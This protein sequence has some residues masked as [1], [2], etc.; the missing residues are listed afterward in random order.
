MKTRTCLSFAFL[1]LLITG[2]SFACRIIV[3]QEPMPL[4]RP[5]RSSRQPIITKSHKAEI[6]ITNQAVSTKVEAVF[7]N[8]NPR[9]LEGTYFFPLPQN[10]AVSRFS[11]FMNNKEVKGELL[12]AAKARKFYEDIVRK[13]KDPGLL[14]FSDMRTIKV[15]VFPIP[16]NGDVKIRLSYQHPIVRRGTLHEYIY[17]LRSAMPEANKTIQNVSLR[18]KIQS[19][20][21]LK[22]IYSP[23]HDIDVIR[24]NEIS[25]TAGFEARNM[26]PDKDFKLYWTND[27][28][29]IGINVLTHHPNDSEDGYFMLMASPSLNIKQKKVMARDIVFVFDKSGSMQEDDKIKQ[30]RAALK[31]CLSKLKPNDRFSILA[32]STGTRTFKNKMVPASAENIKAGLSFVAELEAGGGTAMDEALRQGL[33]MFESTSNLPMMLFLTDGRPTVGITDIDKILQGFNDSNKTQARAFVFGVGYDVNTKLL[34][35]L[36][37]QGRGVREYVTPEEDI[38][39]KV[40]GLYEK[41]SSPVLADINISCSAADIYD[42]FPKQIPD[43]FKG[44]QMVLFGRYKKDGKTSL[45]ISGKT[46]GTEKEFIHTVDFGRRKSADFMPLLWATRKIGYLLD[47][48]RLHGKN[49]ELVNEVTRLGTKYGIVTP[50]TSF[51][52]VDDNTE[53]P[54]ATRETLRRKVDEVARSET[55]DFEEKSTGRVA[56]DMSKGAGAY[57]QAKSLRALSGPVRVFGRTNQ[58]LKKKLGISRLKIKHVGDK[59]FFLKNRIWQDSEYRES[60]KNDLIWIEFLSKEYFRLLKDHPGIAQYLAVDKN[61]ILCCKGRVYKIDAVKE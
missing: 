57:K 26:L 42:I 44:S 8:P 24:T 25:A 29:E 37:E 56:Q 28:K 31:Y 61:L 9:Q 14:E 10:V 19:D 17:P 30:A 33:K 16:A 6:T 46:S 53:L 1:F 21:G 13:I 11:M 7:H 2:I 4:P 20:Q 18:V 34:D 41:V 51:L 58:D 32:F 39:V 48:I 27:E 5:G 43:I 38:E 40:S 47:Q 45:T 23:T 12:D 60:M 55:R 54:H 36:A 35:R 15:R 22:N 49:R 50:Y 3:P 59:T 52:V